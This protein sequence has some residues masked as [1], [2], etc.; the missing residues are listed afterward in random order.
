[1]PRGARLDAPGT[2]HH[3][4]VRGIERGNIVHDDKD[5]E[6]FVFRMARLAKATGTEIYAWAMMS[7]HV[8]ILLKSGDSGL[9]MFMRKLLTGYAIQFNRKYKRSGH[10]FQNR[11]KSI[12]CDEETYFMKLVSYI[13]LNPLRAGLVSSM[14]ALASYPWSG[15]AVIMG[16]VHNDWQACGYVLDSF[17]EDSRRSKKAYEEYVHE[18]RS[19]GQQPDL[20][21]GGL[22]RSKGGWSAVMSSRTRGEKHFFDERILGSGD[23]VKEV[24][25]QADA[26]IRDQ[27]PVRDREAVIDELIGRRCEEAGISINALQAGSKTKLCSA[28]RKELAV[29]FVRQYGLT[30]ADSARKLGI[31][32][33]AISQIL[34]QC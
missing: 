34:K 11:Y 3:V 16:K 27:I 5:R 31:S 9:S 13:H 26:T 1:M 2:L 15:H 19:L 18:Q 22:V 23:F 29:T 30:Y 28:I 21:G 8:H 4:M 33:S 10:L 25:D 6:D 17:G 12:V 7:N 32:T 14:D 24:L 20:V